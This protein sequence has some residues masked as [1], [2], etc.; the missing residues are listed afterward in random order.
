MKTT[1]AIKHGVLLAF[2]FRLACNDAARS[3]K[4]KTECILD[5]E[6]IPRSR[7]YKTNVNVHFCSL[8]NACICVCCIIC[9]L[10]NM[11]LLSAGLSPLAQRSHKEK[12]C[13]LLRFAINLDT[14]TTNDEAARSINGCHIRRYSDQTQMFRVFRRLFCLKG[15]SLPIHIKTKV[16]F[17]LKLQVT[18]I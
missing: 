12:S 5:A 1:I 10:V 14:K 15:T 2:S 17:L 9:I 13:F 11:F 16:V 7:I 6:F 4:A 3:S 8:I 18:L